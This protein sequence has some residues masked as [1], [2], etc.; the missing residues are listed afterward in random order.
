MDQDQNTVTDSTVF[1][2]RLQTDTVQTVWKFFDPVIP[3]SQTVL[4]SDRLLH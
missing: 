1:L 4:G 3:A 2:L